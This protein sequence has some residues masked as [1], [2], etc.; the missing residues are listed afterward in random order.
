MD[1]SSTLMQLAKPHFVT[2][3][4][5]FAG[6]LL[7]RALVVLTECSLST[8]EVFLLAAETVFVIANESSMP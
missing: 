8:D 7:A 1:L 5:I 6:G 3:A 4:C 2:F